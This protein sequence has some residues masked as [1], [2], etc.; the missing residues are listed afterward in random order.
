MINIAIKF[1]LASG[2]AAAMALV[3][4]PEES[5]SGVPGKGAPLA[6]AVKASADR[7]ELGAARTS[8]PPE[9][10]LEQPLPAPSDPQAAQDLAAKT[11]AAEVIRLSR[12][13][14]AI[15]RV[16]LVYKGQCGVRVSR[17][18]AFGREWFALWDR[19]AQP[20]IDA[21]GCSDLLWRLLQSGENVRRD[22]GRVRATAR[23]ALDPGTEIGMLRW[24]SLQW[25]QLEDRA[26]TR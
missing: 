17:Q 7:P 22:L 21:R 13:A 11:F 4:T 20:A 24:H 26:S 5:T 12:E 23:A 3:G 18:Y 15:D 1:A 2:V 16:W 6:I 19:A 25:S 14:D 9:H 8:V 10:P